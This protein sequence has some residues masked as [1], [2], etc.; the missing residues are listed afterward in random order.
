[1]RI[2]EKIE[3]MADEK[4]RKRSHNDIEK[5]VNYLK[6]LE[7]EGLDETLIEIKDI[8]ESG[9]YE[10][11]IKSCEVENEMP[12]DKIFTV[13]EALK[14]PLLKL[15]DNNLRHGG[16]LTTIFTGSLVT[17]KQILSI[18]SFI[19]YTYSIFTGRPTK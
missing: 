10:R 18:Y 3:E 9:L 5:L 4:E 8:N 17:A 11:L 12:K 1:M 14:V 7:V 13:D 6:N 16:L 2:S 15:A 19:E